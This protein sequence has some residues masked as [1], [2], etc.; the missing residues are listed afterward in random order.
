MIV[1]PNHRILVISEKAELLF[2]DHE[3]LVA[4][5]HLVGREGIESLGATDVTYIHIM[6]DRHEV[7]LSDGAWT[8]SFQ[9]GDYTLAGIGEESREEIFALF[10]ELREATG[11]GGFVAARRI[12][13]KHEAALLN[14]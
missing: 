10:P 3:V 13:R 8:E 6:F 2:E 7:V 9:P 12:L 14:A 1:S 11:R 4:A 5:K